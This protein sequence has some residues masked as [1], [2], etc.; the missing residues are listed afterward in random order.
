MT[1]FDI[2]DDIDEV[3]SIHET[4]ASDGIHYVETSNEWSQWRDELADKMFSDW[5]L[6]NK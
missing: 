6:R 2:L 5:E 4:T 3:D 1:N